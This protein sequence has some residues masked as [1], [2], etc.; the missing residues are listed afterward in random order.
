MGL[1]A[2]RGSPRSA[3]RGTQMPFRLGL[4]V[5]VVLVLIL[6]AGALAEPALDRASLDWIRKEK[7]RAAYFHRWS[8]E[9]LPGKLAAAGFNTMHVQFCN[10]GYPEIKRWGRLARENNLRL[11]TGVWWS[12]PPHRET[13]QGVPSRIGKDYRGFVS[14]AGRRHTRTLCPLDEPYWRDWVMPGFVE[15]AKQAREAG[16]YG[17]TLD[18]EFYGSAEPDGGGS[19]GWYYFGGR[20]H[21][22]HCFDSFLQSIGAAE[23]SADVLP[24]DRDAW[25][26]KR[27]HWA[28][29]DGHLKDNVQ[30]L[31][32]WLEQAVHAIDSDVLLGFLAVYAADDFF[33]RGL[34]DGFKTPDRPVMIWTET[35]TYWKGYRPYVDDVYSELQSIGDVL[36]VPGL[37]LEAHA[38]MTLGKQ[39]HDL[40][41]HSDGYWIFTNKK[42]L[43]L[44]ATIGNYFAGGNKAIA[45]AAPT[46]DDAP[47][48]DLWDEYDPVLTLPARWQLRL[49]PKDVGRKEAW[50]AV[51]LDVTDW[52]AVAITDFWGKALGRPHTGAGW[53]RVTVSV[54][55]SAAGKKLYLAFGAVDEEAW[56]W[57]NGEPSGEHAEGPQGWNKRFLIEVTDQLKAGKKNLI[58]VRVYN[59]LAAGGIWKPVRLIAGK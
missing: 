10:A 54:P 4:T 18:P 7:I 36:Y 30:V 17:I 44:N 56:I 5:S 53:Y 46:S 29:Y 21:C 57:V 27:D 1:S 48:V 37:Y 42:D 22:D 25:L 52:Q 34:R 39:V 19:L 6:A 8:S 55:S 13:Q 26:K 51:D 47:F 2:W 24:K 45:S 28:A 41:M 40:A 20:C 12:Y 43:F 14:S 9:E 38:P 59:S 23:S 15:M 3:K 11:I 16:V 32:R 49:D 31:A 50:Y 35:G 58:V 33:S